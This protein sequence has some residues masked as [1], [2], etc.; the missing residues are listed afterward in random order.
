[1]EKAAFALVY[2]ADAP[3]TWT[4]VLGMTRQRR[5]RILDMLAKQKQAE[6]KAIE[7]AKRGK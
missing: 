2:G 5:M 4:E 1:M 7:D 6:E 3:L